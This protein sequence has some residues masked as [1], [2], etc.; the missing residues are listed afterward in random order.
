MNFVVNQP[1]LGMFVFRVFIGCAMAF[2]HGLGKVPPPE[3]LVAGVTAMGFPIPLFFAW[4]AAAS[5]LVGGLL[6]ALG[7]YTRLA[8]LA[9][10]CMPRIRLVPKKWPYY[11][12]WRACY[13][14]FKARAG[15]LSIISSEK[16]KG[17]EYEVGLHLVVC[18]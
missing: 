11:I 10:K 3:Q 14:F 13:L 4:C 6:I 16:S 15:F 9:L 2:S 18:R 5:E 12:L 7:W 8:A 17:Y 1:N